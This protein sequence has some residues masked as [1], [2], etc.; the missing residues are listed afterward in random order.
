MSEDNHLRSLV[1][2][3]VEFVLENQNHPGGSEGD[4]EN[5]GHLIQE[6]GTV[7]VRDGASALHEELEGVL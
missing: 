4:E 7:Q 2:E 1:V 3:H 6:H 5:A